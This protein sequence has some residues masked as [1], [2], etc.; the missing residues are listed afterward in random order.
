LTDKEAKEHFYLL[1]VCVKLLT[2]VTKPAGF[3]IG[4]NLGK[5]SGAGLDDHLHTHVV[6]RWL[7]DTNFMAVTADTRVLSEGLADT[8]KKLKD[9]L[10][11][12]L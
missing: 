1:K 4:M 8:Y 10:A 3:N 5:V 12:V 6:P 2:E 9:G 11:T 7:G